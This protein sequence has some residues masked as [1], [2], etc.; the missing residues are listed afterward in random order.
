MGRRIAGSD[1]ATG[2]GDAPAAW[3]EG[4]RS[5]TTTRDAWQPPLPLP[6]QL[7]RPVSDHD[8]AHPAELDLARILTYY[9]VRWVYEP[10]TFPLA[11]AADGHVS[12]MFTPDF[13][14][15]DLRLYI[16]ITTMRQRLVTRKNR[17][18]RR[19]RELYPTIRIKLLYRRDYHRLVD[20]YWPVGRELREC[21]VGRILFSTDQIQTRVTQ[22][23]EEIAAGERRAATAAEPP[24]LVLGV[25]RGSEVF[26]GALTGRLAAR[27]LPFD[28]DRVSLS[29]FTTSM[30]ER[31]VRVG[32][33]PR[34]PLAGR[35][36]LLVTDAISTGLSLAYLTAWL[37][38][39]GVRRVDICTL[40]DRREARL[41]DV[42]IRYV[43]F[44]APNEL[45]IGFGLHLRRRFH[46][47]PY[48]A[49]LAVGSLPD[50]SALP[51]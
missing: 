11:W 48:I 26:L 39:R 3:D 13:Y 37:R 30:G 45:L 22:L 42:A 21:R 20:C 12:E 27:R 16:E 32:R 44:E 8:F 50:G 43:G 34:L 1:D 5:A 51:R 4:E 2:E 7:I 40:L 10:T 23:A 19:L 31:R 15:P 25:G 18:L 49:S 17:K 24:L 33:S 29:R 46:N 28:V 36:V 41:L 38:R 35:A 9:R 14:L 6:W 47:L